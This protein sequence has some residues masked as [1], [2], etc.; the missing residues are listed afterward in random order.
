MAEKH[1]SIEALRKAA[2]EGQ[3]KYVTVRRDDLKAIE[4]YV[5]VLERAN[6]VVHVDRE[7]LL[8][9]LSPKKS[10]SKK[11]EHDSSH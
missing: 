9:A 8:G 3:T 10:A 2:E 7:A 11:A 4:V 5:P 6:E 1:D